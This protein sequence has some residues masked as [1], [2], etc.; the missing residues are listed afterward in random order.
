MDLN[1]ARKEDWS[2]DQSYSLKQYLNMPSQSYSL[3]QYLDMPSQSYSLKQY[4][5]R[6]A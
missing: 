3:K 5:P 6:Y 1:I 2:V 4:L